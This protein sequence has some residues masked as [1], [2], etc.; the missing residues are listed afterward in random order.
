MKKL[1]IILVLLI[2]TIQ[3]QG[4]V[5]GW[6]RAD[7]Y[8]IPVSEET[9]SAIARLFWSLENSTE[10]VITIDSGGVESD[11]TLGGASGAE[12]APWIQKGKVYTFRLYAVENGVRAVVDSISVSGTRPLPNSSIGLN[13]FP[14][15]AQYLGISQGN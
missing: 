2:M 1:N 7:M 6:L 12:L 13:A 3:L 11:F 8:T 4:Q 14:L 15:F 10:S 5:D 9:D